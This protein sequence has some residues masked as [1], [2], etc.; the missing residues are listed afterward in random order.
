MYA[1]IALLLTSPCQADFRRQRCSEQGMKA[2]LMC[3]Q[4][5]EGCYFPI[6]GPPVKLLPCLASLKTRLCIDQSVGE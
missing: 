6:K 2:R 4:F 3:E 5:S 1:L